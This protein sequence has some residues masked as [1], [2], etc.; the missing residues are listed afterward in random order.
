MAE[1]AKATGPAPGTAQA[2]EREETAFKF[3]SGPTDEGIPYQVPELPPHFVPRAELVA[4]KKLLTDRSATS[5]API[6]LHGLSGSGKTALAAA[7]AHDADVLKAFPDG[8]L[9]VSLGDAGDIQHAQAIWGG[10]LGNDLSHIPDTASRSAALR[11]LLHESQC[12]LVIDDVSEMEQIKALNVGGPSCMRLITTDLANEI[13][14]AIKARRYAIDRLSE[15]EA[16]DLLV[17]WAGILPDIYLPTVK[18]IIKRLGGSALALALV[19]A[20]ARQGITWLRLL[21]VLRD[22]QG[23]IA[24]LKPDDPDTRR[25][26]L[27][28]VVNLVLSRFG[29]AQLKRSALLGT[30]VAGTGAP[31]SV[32]AAAACWEMSFEAAHETLE[33][34][35]EAALVQRLPGQYYAMHKALRDHLRR[36]STPNELLEAGRRVRAYYLQRVERASTGASTEEIDAQLEQVMVAYRATSQQEES[37]AR[38]FADALMSYFEQR[39]LWSNLVTLAEAEVEEAK[40]KKDTLREHVYLNDLGYARTVLGNLEEAVTCFERSLEVSRALG[41]PAGEAAALN[42]IGAIH[43]RKGEF[44]QALEYYERSLSIRQALGV[45]EDIAETLNNV[46][47]VLHWQE[48]WDE[49]LSTFQR[50]LDMYNVLGNRH[51][52]AQTL[53]N[54]GATY[55]RMND[56][57]EAQQAYQRSLAIYS[58]LDDEA[59]QAQALNNLGI[60][61]LNRGDTDRALTHFKRSLALKERLGDRHGQASTLNNIALLYEKTGSPTLAL[62]HYEQSFKILEA[63]GD[64]R[65]EVV[66]ENIDT[67][68]EQMKKE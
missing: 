25:N 59:G 34:L 30:F 31:F 65:A 45:R 26:A 53:L 21:E 66:Q 48:R 22:D 44:V 51:G 64:T 42:N 37:M 46:A 6:V 50:V 2:N 63:L 10:V 61:H 15:K 67:L 3:V 52:Q 1:Q 20:Q 57:V 33:L 62:E 56:D 60:V 32:G 4:I 18:E 24:S 55:E 8:V 47:G 43:E 11:T 17:E 58:N 19:G 39:G 7:V 54:I 16:L 14:L 5:L 28:L 49:A 68:Q 23:P 35:V 29:G 38:I 27:G 12:L 9:W 40:E 36:A 13:S 41:D